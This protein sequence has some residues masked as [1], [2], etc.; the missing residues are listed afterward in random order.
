MGL[1]RGAMLSLSALLASCT[2]RVQLGEDSPLAG[3]VSLTISPPQQTIDLVGLGGPPVTAEYTAMGE[4]TDGTTRD[5][6]ASVQWQV[7]NPAPGGFA[8]DNRY[9]ASRRAAGDVT[10]RAVA[11][12]LVATGRLRV[13]MTASLNDSAFP[14]PLGAEA[15][16]AAATPISDAARAPKFLYP[17]HDTLFPQGLAHVV[18][19]HQLGPG[20]DV[21]RL[22]F[23]SDVLQ[24]DVL[25][26]AERWQ[27]DRDL[28]YLLSASHPGAAVSVTLDGA[29]MAAPSNAY[30]SAPET[31]RFG[32]ADPG[33][34]LSFVA[35]GK[36]SL[37]RAGL[38]AAT[39]T[40]FYP[41][42]G[43]LTL[44]T[45][46]TISRDGELMA[47]SYGNGLL[48]VVRLADLS[49]Q[50][51]ASAG[52]PMGWAT[53]SPDG[54]RI[55]VANDGELV[56]RDA[57]T[58]APVGPG[59]GRVALPSK[60]THPDWSP[61][62][63]QVAVVISNEISNGDVR[64]G[65]IAV[66]PYEQ[67]LFGAPKVLVR[68]EAMYGNSFPRWSP[69]GRFLAYVA[70]KSGPRDAKSAELRIVAAT[71]GAP[72]ALALANHRVNGAAELD[73]LNNT[74]PWWSPSGSADVAWLAFS[75]TRPYGAILPGT[76]RAQIWVA[77]V[78]LT[79]TEDPSF[80]AFWLPAQDVRAVASEP[81]WALDRT[82]DVE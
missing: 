42:P 76:D 18:F 52:L 46:H 67:G 37:V 80:A 62:G 28:W 40:L 64:N 22:R 79:R 48:Q 61:D 31:L 78:D 63:S 69:D 65:A 35:S 27:P 11:G 55:L 71:G 7:D 16:F 82:L 81:V 56:L 53:F 30:A 72:R 34:A 32:A 57:L 41:R 47:M 44:V 43:D 66:L 21:L 4:F 73:N 74:A 58:G 54:S 8:T 38:A 1:A 20:N 13:T 49:V 77:G 12:D 19:Q 75:S 45:N 2:E 5:L 68:A 26:T 50:V 14:A 17:C 60:A 36:N 29:A 10:I 59:G 9:R 3:L 23:T 70:T 24:L 25:T 39:G 51:P 15:L 6:S 33:G